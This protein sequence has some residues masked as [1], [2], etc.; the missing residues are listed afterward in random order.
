MVFPYA[1]ELPTSDVDGPGEPFTSSSTFLVSGFI[2]PQESISDCSNLKPISEGHET[3]KSEPLGASTGSAHCLAYAPQAGLSSSS[4][5]S[6]KTPRQYDLGT[7]G[8]AQPST[9]ADTSESP[10]STAY[11]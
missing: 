3:C 7:L 11:D 10:F 9:W 1:F 6:L 2:Y 5:Q 4:Y 8:L